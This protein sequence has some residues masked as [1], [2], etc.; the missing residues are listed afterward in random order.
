MNLPRI[1]A[2]SPD[3]FRA[4]YARP[5]IPV[6]LE[7]LV[8]QR[9]SFAS[10][11]ERHADVRVRVAQRRDG[12][13]LVDARKG[14]LTREMTLG[15]FLGSLGETS[16]Y[17]MTRL[18]EL[19]DEL[20]PQMPAYCSRASFCDAKL[21]ISPANTVSAL[22]F[23]LADNLHTVLAGRKRFILYSADQSELVYPRGLFSSVPNGALV[24]PEAPDLARFPRLARAKPWTAVL[25]PGD[26]IFIPHRH[27]HHVRT[28]E[29]AIAVNWW[30]AAG[31]R[32]LLVKAADAFKRVSGISR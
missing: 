27:W 1:Q 21:W 13:V 26:T 7:G 11:A 29:P 22:H 3:E 2:P 16:G 24:D 23:D 28:L 32:R 18:A 31:A 15:S 9:W 4:T 17:L 10:L 12:R 6:V 30:F 5:S 8:E 25:G 19:P 14:L 20:R